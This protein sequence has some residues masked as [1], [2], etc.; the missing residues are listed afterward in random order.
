MNRK[1]IRNKQFRRDVFINV[2]YL[3]V[4]PRYP[5]GFGYEHFRVRNFINAIMKDKSFANEK[6]D[7]LKMPYEKFLEEYSTVIY[8]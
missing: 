2:L 8:N 6:H 3:R 5:S 7:M 4:E 1:K